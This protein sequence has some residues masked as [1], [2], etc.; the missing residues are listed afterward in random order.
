[1]DD[2]GNLI[3]ETEATERRRAGMEEGGNA[4]AAVPE[5]QEG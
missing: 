1:M 2:E 5:F 4:I 3:G